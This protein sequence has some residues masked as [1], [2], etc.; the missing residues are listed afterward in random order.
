MTYRLFLRDLLGLRDERL[1]EGASTDAFKGAIDLLLSLR[2]EAKSR[3]DWATSDKIRDELT[4]L[5]FV[6]KDTKEGTEWSL[7]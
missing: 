6:I 4:A 7:A 5:G 2:Q 3:K 1:S